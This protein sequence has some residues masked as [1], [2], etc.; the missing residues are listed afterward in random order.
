MPILLKM[1]VYISKKYSGIGADLQNETVGAADTAPT[2]RVF[3]EVGWV[4]RVAQTSSCLALW[5]DCLEAA[6]VR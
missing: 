6:E 5:A 3:V 1:A 4:G 2:L